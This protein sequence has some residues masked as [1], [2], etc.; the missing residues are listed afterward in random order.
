MSDVWEPASDLREREA[1]D[2]YRGTSPYAPSALDSALSGLDA[3]FAGSTLIATI[4]PVDPVSQRPNALFFAIAGDVDDDATW[5]RLVNANRYLAQ[6]SAETTS[7]N[8][9][10]ALLRLHLVVANLPNPRPL[11]DARDVWF[12]R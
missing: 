8:T 10:E 5:G 1:I 11:V 12:R 9:D 3:S 4:A 6:A 2:W 7:R